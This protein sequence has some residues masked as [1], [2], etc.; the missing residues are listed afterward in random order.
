MA[1]GTETQALVQKAATTV[2]AP[3]TLGFV[4]CMALMVGFLLMLMSA[5]FPG[6]ARE[7]Q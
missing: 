1:A 6:A 5:F 4:D 3:M 2:T 7:G